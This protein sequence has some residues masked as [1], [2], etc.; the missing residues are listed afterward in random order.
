MIK[1]YALVTG[2]SSGIGLEISKILASIGF[3]LVLV[4]RR[5]DKLKEVTKTLINK[6]D[7]TADYCVGDLENPNIPQIIY[8]F[9]HKK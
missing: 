8:D 5:E 4:A 1:K 6:Y 3:S 2:A 9:C 7:I